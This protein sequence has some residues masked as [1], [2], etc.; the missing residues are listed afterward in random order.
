[1]IIYKELITVD[2]FNDSENESL[3]LSSHFLPPN[4]SVQKFETGWAMKL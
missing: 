1:M 3:S 4:Y 2:I